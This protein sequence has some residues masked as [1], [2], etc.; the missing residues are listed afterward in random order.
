M[1]RKG[2]EPIADVYITA[3]FESAAYSLLIKYCKERLW[4]ERDV[5]VFYAFVDISCL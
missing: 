4:D 5:C 3:T 2:K 1:E